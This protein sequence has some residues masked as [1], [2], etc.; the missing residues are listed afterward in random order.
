MSKRSVLI[1]ALLSS[2][3]NQSTLSF[4]VVSRYKGKGKEKMGSIHMQQTKLSFRPTLKMQ[5][6]RLREIVIEQLGTCI[7]VNSEVFKLFRRVHLV[8]FRS[9]QQVSTLLTPC[10]LTR[11]HKRSYASYLFAR[12]ANIWSSRDELLEYE[13]AI[14]LEGW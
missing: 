5:K 12:T 4:P 10:I 3:C 1:D 13:E 9:T 6:D 11:A 7:R 8:Y 14:D 2:S